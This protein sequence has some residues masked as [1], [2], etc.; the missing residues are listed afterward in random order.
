MDID[1]EISILIKNDK[2]VQKINVMIIGDKKNGKSTLIKSFFSLLG[3]FPQ[4]NFLADSVKISETFLPS[5]GVENKLSFVEMDLDPNVLK[6]VDK[7]HNFLRDG[8]NFLCFVIKTID[9]S[10][11]KNKSRIDLFFNRFEQISNYFSKCLVIWNEF[12]ECKK[13]Q[14]LF[15]PIDILSNYL[16]KLNLKNMFNGKRFNVNVIF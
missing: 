10:I 12:N 1:K 16:D 4:T 6:R 8:Q 15:A 5:T 2:T 11:L 9:N 7:F 13:D 3:L 14:L